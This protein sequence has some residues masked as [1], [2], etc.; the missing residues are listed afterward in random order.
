MDVYD[1]VRDIRKVRESGVGLNLD[2]VPALKEALE[3]RWSEDT[4]R[5]RSLEELLT[6][7]ASKLN[8]RD[9]MGIRLALG[10]GGMG[11]SSADRRAAFAAHSDRT[12]DAVCKPRTRGP[13][14]EEEV[15]TALA[16]AVLSL[17][18]I[19]STT[20]S[21]AGADGS[22]RLHRDAPISARPEKK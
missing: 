4:T 8:E 9:A 12:A 18:E 2:Q 3:R 15:F 22:V 19:G 6:E 16:R 13:S 14:L 7:A 11:G 10:I 1:L 20:A 17:P 5:A 21:V